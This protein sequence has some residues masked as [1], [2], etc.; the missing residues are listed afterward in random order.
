MGM[1]CMFGA[2]GGCRWWVVVVFALW[3]RAIQGCTSPPLAAFQSAT[4]M[5]SERIESL[6]SRLLAHQWGGWYR[7]EYDRQVAEVEEQVLKHESAG[8]ISA[9]LRVVNLGLTVWPQSATLLECRAALYGSLGY[10]RAAEC[11][12]ALASE[13]R[14]EKAATWEALGRCRQ[15]LGLWNGARSARSEAKRLT[16][17]P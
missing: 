11:G 16:L 15:E 14:P 5:G 4:E 13:L 3:I 2:H 1:D 8:D 7:A 10:W 17:A 12:F 9:A 6:E